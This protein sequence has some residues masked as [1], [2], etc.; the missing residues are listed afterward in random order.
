M[1][2]TVSAPDVNE[3]PTIDRDESNGFL[4]SILS[5]A[6]N[7]A[8]MIE[9]ISKDENKPGLAQNALGM[10]GKL[11][12]LLQGEAISNI[13]SRSELSS[14]A[15]AVS[16]SHSP[17]AVGNGSQLSRVLLASNV[18][19]EPVHHSPVSTMGNGNLLLLHFD[20][21][22]K[23]TMSLSDDALKVAVSGGLA[24]AAAET[25]SNRLLVSGTDGKIVR[26]KS[27]SN[28]STN[29]QNVN[30]HDDD[31]ISNAES[32][33]TETSEAG[34]NQELEQI[35]DSAT[36]SRA[37]KK[38][39]REFHNAF[40]K[41]PSGERLIGDYSCALSK[42]ILVQGKMYLSQHYICFNSNI[43]GWVTNIAI[44]LQEVIQ[45]EKKSTAVLFPN[46]M[47]IRTLHQKF[48]FATFLS[49]D[50]TFNV[51]T[52]VWHEAL[53]EKS[54]DEAGG[55][56]RVNTVRSRGR[57]FAD[58][59]TTSAGASDFSDAD[60]LLDP[61]GTSSTNSV[62]DK[63][64][65]RPDGPSRLPSTRAIR[66]KK[67]EAQEDPSLDEAE[68]LDSDDENSN[69]NEGRSSSPGDK[70]GDTFNGFK[71]P[72]PKSHSPTKSNYTKDSNDVD[73]TEV[74][75]RA[76]LGVVYELLF[77]KDNSTYVK[78][79]ENQ[80]NFDILSGKIV[81][82]SNDNKE[83][84]YSY[85]KPLG[86]A[87]GPKQTKC[88]ITDTVK[89]CDFNKY[90]EV[91]QVT[92]TPDVPSGNSFKVKT[93][94]FFTWA[95]DNTTK[96]SVVTAIEWSAK[97]WIKSAIE[98]G[99]I[100]GQKDSMKVLADTLTDIISSGGS[101]SPTKKKRKKA[102][103]VSSPTPPKV[104]EKEETKPLSLAE[105][106]TN[107]LEE[108]GKVIPVSIPFISTAMTGMLVVVFFSFI[109]SFCLLWL[110]GGSGKKMNLQ[111]FNSED[112]LT[113]LVRVNGQKYFMLPSSDTY[114]SDQGN[115]KVNEAKMWNWI[116]ERSQGHVKG[117]KLFEKKDSSYD[118]FVG[119][120]F[121]EVV[122]MA[123]KRIDQ[124]YDQLDLS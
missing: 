38:K 40:R 59:D 96:M 114:L 49:R 7:A 78:I 100:D 35:L 13:S 51:I 43:L 80:K 101:S 99:S 108:I 95:A 34:S 10:N 86:G 6:H 66:A 25:T 39:N 73:I 62:D 27:I 110:I 2:A 74:T 19:F 117:G 107:L 98:K 75:F 9:A 77:G 23:H 70:G 116:N 44:P 31:V 94:L 102:K 65:G 61:I 122:R 54:K 47:I 118:D 55:R 90:V 88:L 18:H 68:L 60:L 12:Q 113:K 92:Q 81:G 123:K 20:S 105:Q 42:D 85:I 87:I 46:G 37:S 4:S 91:E 11:N 22:R 30:G 57:S 58:H 97:S 1:A 89:F 29:E 28:G 84:D 8:H 53:L 15:A 41:I 5:A 82:I 69:G 109:Y 124:L 21:K 56:K 50:A 71:N 36:I 120:E 115:R 83:R 26:R 119:Q 93:R 76:P 17:T 112:A 67:L 14:S 103:S 111:V 3:Q 104:V 72:G 106:L 32:L 48:V 33:L 24:P 64:N 16:G 121:D 79:L 63:Q 52:K 45:I